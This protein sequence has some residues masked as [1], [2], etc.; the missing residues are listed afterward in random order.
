[1]IAKKINSSTIRCNNSYEAK[2]LERVL[3][4]VTTMNQPIEMDAPLIY[5]E[6]KD[7]VRAQY[8]IRTDR[9]EIGADAMNKI[10]TELQNRRNKKVE[11]NS[12]S[13]TEPNKTAEK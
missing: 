6:R 7:G 12:E 4:E 10:A 3:E 1:M 8:D 13:K 5:T 2:P 11:D 9:F